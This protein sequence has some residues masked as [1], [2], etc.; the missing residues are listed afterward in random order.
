MNFLNDGTDKDTPGNNK[1][2]CPLGKNAIR[3][4]KNY[5]HSVNLVLN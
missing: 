4:G 5:L 3:K 1:E 2:A